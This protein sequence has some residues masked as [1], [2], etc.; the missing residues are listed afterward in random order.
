M[1]EL[2][3]RP[4]QKLKPLFE[5]DDNG[6]Q[7]YTLLMGGRGS[8]KS[9][10]MADWS[11]HQ[12]RKRYQL[13]MCC[14]QFAKSIGESM[15]PLLE[16]RI[17]H[18]GFQSEFVIGRYEIEHKVTGS[19]WIQKGLDRNP[20]SIQSTQGVS[21][22]LVEEAQFI[23]M[24]AW[25]ALTPTIRHRGSRFVL[26]MNP[27]FDNDPVYADLV[28]GERANETTLIRLNWQDN[29]H[30][31]DELEAE[32]LADEK[33]D[34]DLYKWIWEGELLQYSDATVFK[35]GTH[36]DTEPEPE[37]MPDDAPFVYGLDIGMTQARCS[38]PIGR[39]SPPWREPV[40]ARRP[41][42]A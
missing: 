12:G 35:R 7:R 31:N 25:K 33:G 41:G 14:R 26:A 6:Y 19:K 36:W 42:P 23:P 5:P 30:W 2:E 8:G 1:D 15:H 4:A 29:P 21:C 16:E 17:H 10:A 24:T 18:H 34:A 13:F 37:D 3:W 27:R 28:L 9:Y 32:R 11:L 22:A 20:G 39:C 40:S 38:W